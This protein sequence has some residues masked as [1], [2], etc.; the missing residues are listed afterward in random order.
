MKR[1]STRSQGVLI[2]ASSGVLKD[3]AG[4]GEGGIH[5]DSPGVHTERSGAEVVEELRL[6]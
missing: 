4:N 6:Q 5:F 3:L 2:S 1:R